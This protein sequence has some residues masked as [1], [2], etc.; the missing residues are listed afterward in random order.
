MF[1]IGAGWVFYLNA[2]TFIAMIVAI[3]LL[4]T[5]QLIATPRLSRWKGSV[6][7]GLRYV[8][9][10]SDLK[11][12]MITAF[13]LG[14][15][16]LNF[17]IFASTMTTIEF[18]L[19]VGQYGVL[20]SSLAVGAVIGAL[21]AASRDRPRF[22]VI[23]IGAVGLG[24]ALG[25]A[26]FMPTYWAFAVFLMLSGIGVQTVLAS[27][28][29]TVQLTAAPEVRGRVLAIYFTILQGGTIIGAPAVG[30]VTNALGP[31]AGILVGAAAAPWL[32]RSS[33]SIWC[34]A[35][36]SGSASGGR[37]AAP[38][39]SRSSELEEVAARKL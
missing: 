34:A 13:L 5:T 17:P 8:R 1:L 27:T 31:R 3:R 32:P 30:W 25:V 39:P 11:V 33:S 36:A 26:A 2:L 20:L 7:D 16:V 37:S 24:F 9:S 14:A 10:R 12:A 19:G 28:N 38:T 15:F 6:L 29:A 18:G 21:F 22:S 23:A 4:D 35:R